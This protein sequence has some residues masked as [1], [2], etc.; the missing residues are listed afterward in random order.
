MEGAKPGEI[1]AGFFQA[2]VFTDYADDVRLLL[3]AFRE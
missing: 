2:H 1:R 3:H